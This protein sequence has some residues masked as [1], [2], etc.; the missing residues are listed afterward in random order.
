M[1][2]SDSTWRNCHRMCRALWV[3]MLV[4]FAGHMSAQQDPATILT[5]AQMPKVA[6]VDPRFVSYNIEMVEVTGGRFWKPYSAETLAGPAAKAITP[7]TTPS[8]GLD[9]SLFQYRP[10]ID[11]TNSRLRNLAKAI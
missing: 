5:P 11:L 4:I 3:V 9:T 10:P 1:S 6:T 8:A 7:N 2:N